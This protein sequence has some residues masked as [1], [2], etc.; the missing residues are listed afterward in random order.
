MK[1]LTTMRSKVDSLNE[2]FG[3]LSPE[4]ILES[5]LLEYGSEAV[6]SSGFGPSGLVLMHKLSLL[7]PGAKVF[8]L[9]TDLLFGETYSLIQ[10][11]EVRLNL[12]FVKVRSH[13]SLDQQAREY[14][15]ELWKSSPD[16]CCYLRKVLPLKSFL[17][18]KK[19]WITAIR[20]DQSETRR[21]SPVVSWSE[22]FG[23]IKVNPMVNWTEDDVWSYIHLNEIP[24]NELH[25][26]DYPSIG[27]IPCTRPVA[28]GSGLRSGRWA[29]LTKTECGIH[30]R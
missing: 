10:A 7:K 30:E 12:R 28:P 23:V 17:D 22:T 21:D 11:L 15:D 1:N 19:A 6:M 5:V 2:K 14:G 13:L 20:K 3:S 24:Y 26:R 25:D 18:D 9:D 29:G 8:Y 27:C 16:K 4:D